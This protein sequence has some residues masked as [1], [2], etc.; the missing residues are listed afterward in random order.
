MGSAV[1]NASGSNSGS[2]SINGL[3]QPQATDLAIKG[4][5]AVER[6]LIAQNSGCVRIAEHSYSADVSHSAQ[7]YGAPGRL[8]PGGDF[9]RDN[10]TASNPHGSESADGSRGIQGRQAAEEDLLFNI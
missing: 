3:C 4:L 8:H 10:E 5:Y 7:Y 2:S 1:D 6:A 9:R